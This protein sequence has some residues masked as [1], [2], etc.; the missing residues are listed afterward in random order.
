MSNCPHC[1]TPIDGEPKF[2]PACGS[3]LQETQTSEEKRETSAS[4]PTFSPPKHFMRYAVLVIVC[5]ILGLTCPDK[6]AHVDAV[7]SELTDVLKKN[8]KNELETS[9]YASL[10]ESIITKVLNA[11]LKVHNYVFFSTGVLEEGDKNKTVSVGVLGKVFTCGID[12]AAF[13]DMKDKAGKTM[14]G[15]DL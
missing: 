13:D 12:Q 9:M 6:Q 3:A 10:G 8:S 7:Q 4:K 5:I 11:K 1:G 2:C 15:T 14:E